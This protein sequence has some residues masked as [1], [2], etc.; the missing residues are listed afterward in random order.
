MEEY[1]LT[2]DTGGVADTPFVVDTSHVWIRVCCMNLRS[3]APFF[4]AAMVLRA[5][6]NEGLVRAR[7]GTEKDYYC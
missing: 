7:G 4:F 3:Q 5:E 6:K 1:T 2:V